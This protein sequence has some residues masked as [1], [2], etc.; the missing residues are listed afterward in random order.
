M[1]KAIKLIIKDNTTIDVYFDDGKVKRLDVLSLTNEFSQISTLKNRELFVKGKLLGWGAI[2]WN[3]EIDIDTEIIYEEGKNVSEQYDDIETVII[4]YKLKEKR[5]SLFLS[6]KEVARKADI[7]QSDLSKIEKGI[8]NPSIKQI[9][10]VLSAL[11]HR[12]TIE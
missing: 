11:N 9:T 8:A 4:G 7:D 3:D 2:Q 1:K 5:L 12:L 10:R 6:Q